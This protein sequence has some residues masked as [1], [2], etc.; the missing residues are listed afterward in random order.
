VSEQPLFFY[1][2]ASPYAYLAA[3]RIGE[4]LPE[5]EWRPIL[6][7]GLFKLNGRHSWLYDDDRETRHTE[8][9]RRAAAY[10][11]PPLAWFKNIPTT[12][13]TV[14]RAVTVAKR[15]GRGR[16]FSLAAFRA[17]HAEGRELWHDDQ[18]AT[19]APVAGLEPDEL[20]EAVAQ[21]EIKD[22]LRAAT[23]RAHELG[24]PGV[25]TVVIGDRVFWGDDRLDE[26]ARVASTPSTA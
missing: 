21:Q 11:L 24:A 13:L 25:P 20:L 1:D 19:L 22:E 3:N 23:E 15:R 12:W 5:A 14:M 18:L 4:V 8:I 16:E 26:A 10:G 6:L 7:G 9:E 17:V 2:V